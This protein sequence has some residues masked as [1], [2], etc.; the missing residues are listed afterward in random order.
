MTLFMES[1]RV[2]RRRFLNTLRGV[3]KFHGP[4]ETKMSATVHPLH[5]P[6]VFA[7]VKPIGNGFAPPEHEVNMPSIVIWRCTC[8]KRYRALLARAQNIGKTTVRCAG[9]AREQTGPFTGAVIEVQ[10]E[11]GRW[12]KTSPKEDPSRN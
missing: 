2:R 9:C 1:G 3:E 11:F 6:I 10:D 7:G 5:E 4:G 8:G 12:L